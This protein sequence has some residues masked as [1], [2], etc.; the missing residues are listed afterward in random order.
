MPG[1]LLPIVLLMLPMTAFAVEQPK[2]INIGVG[3]YGLVVANDSNVLDD[4]Q[5]TGTHLCVPQDV[6]EGVFAYGAVRPQIAA[7]EGIPHTR[8]SPHDLFFCAST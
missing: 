1:V 2:K 8:E 6:R 5:L 4:D 7:E 3:S